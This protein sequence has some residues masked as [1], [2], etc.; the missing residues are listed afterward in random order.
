MFKITGIDH[1]VLRTQSLKAMV[2]F[3]CNALG[4]TIENEQPEIGLTQI[5]AGN[6]LIDL[7]ENKALPTKGQANMDHFCLCIQ[8]FSFEALQ[9]HFKQLNIEVHRYGK[10]YGATGMAY[11]FYVFDPEGNE[12]E[13]REVI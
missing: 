9:A 4:C 10:R 11:S 13:L 1:L 8:P 7:V 6:N 3:Y 5:R 2:A 12:V